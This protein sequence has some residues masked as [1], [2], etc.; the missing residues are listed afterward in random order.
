MRVA[1][2]GAGLGGL[3][4]AAHLVAA[5][6]RVT[7]FERTGAA[8]GRA[9]VEVQ[10]GFRMALGPTVLTMPQLVGEAFAALGADLERELTITPLDPTYRAVFADGSEFR[11][12]RGRDAWSTR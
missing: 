1:V 2:V 12:R 4:A 5:G 9:T 7:V 8:G 3:S 10:D 11:V 6:H